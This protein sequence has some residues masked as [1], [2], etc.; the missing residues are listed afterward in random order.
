MSLAC[1][2]R[3]KVR[4]LKRMLKL[5]PIESKDFYD[6]FGID[7]DTG[8]IIERLLNNSCINVDL[9]RVLF[10][11]L[12]SDTLTEEDAEKVIEYLYKH[13]INPIKGGNRYQAKDII[14]ELKRHT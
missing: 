13:Q 5:S 12:Y 4:T 2:A 11:R 8:N 6:V 10:Q 14:N 7:Y 3:M 1:L 9:E